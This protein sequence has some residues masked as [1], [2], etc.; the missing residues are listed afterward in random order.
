M[1]T[2]WT[3]TCLHNT[4]SGHGSRYPQDPETAAQG[5]CSFTGSGPE[6]L[7]GESGHLGQPRNGPEGAN[8]NAHSLACWVVLANKPT[9][10][11]SNRPLRTLFC[12]AGS[13]HPPLLPRARGAR[14]RCNFTSSRPENLGGREWPLRETKN[15]SGEANTNAPSLACWASVGQQTNAEV[16]GCQGKPQENFRAVAVCG[17]NCEI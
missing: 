4:G 15:K 7:G 5:R 6:N 3:R 8:M 17:D 1:D 14:G 10:V 13:R 16:R 2:R 9:K 11:R 12:R